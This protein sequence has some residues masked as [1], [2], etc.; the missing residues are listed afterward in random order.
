MDSSFIFTGG[1]VRGIFRSTSLQLAYGDD[2]IITTNI[3]ELSLKCVLWHYQK[4]EIPW[5]LYTNFP[6]HFITTCDETLSSSL[7]VFLSDSSIERYFP[8]RIQGVEELIL[9][10]FVWYRW[11]FVLSLSKFEGH[12]S[13]VYD[14]FDEIKSIMELNITMYSIFYGKTTHLIQEYTTFKI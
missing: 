14:M 12:G 3:V 11:K 5:N 8:R 1:H 9:Q 13:S 6:S 2:N 7:C 10:V 4:P